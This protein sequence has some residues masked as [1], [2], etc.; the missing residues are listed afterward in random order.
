M[1]NKN[2]NP[3]SVI[4]FIAKGETVVTS[5]YHGVY[6]A[7]LLGRKVVCIPYNRKFS[8][9]QYIPVTASENSWK[10][11]IKRAHRTESLL[12]E[13]RDINIRFAK[14]VAELMELDD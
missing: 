14:Q 9:F 12:E 4:D 3:Q 7:Q 5:S 8:T 1:N 13:Y 2:Q 6:W 10:S 11:M